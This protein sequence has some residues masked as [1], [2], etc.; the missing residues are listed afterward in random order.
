MQLRPSTTHAR[1]VLVDLDYKPLGRAGDL[2]RVV[3]A[4]A[5]AEIAVPIHRR[6]GADEG[7]NS[8]LVDQKSGRLVK[9]VGHIFDDFTP[10]VDPVPDKCALG[11]GDKHAIGNKPV[12]ELITQHRF[13]GD[14]GRLKVI[15]PDIFYF[16]GL[17]AVRQGFQKCGRLR[18]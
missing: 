6:D 4:G 13:T 15:D 9:V 18:D 11:S 7:V 14:A 1:H 17:S 10:V 12:I 16:A 8:N 5:E 2:G 3:V